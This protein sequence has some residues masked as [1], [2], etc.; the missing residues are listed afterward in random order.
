[1]T[2]YAEDFEDEDGY[3]DPVFVIEDSDLRA[4][5]DELRAQ[6]EAQ[7]AEREQVAAINREIESFRREHGLRLSPSEVQ[8]LGEMLD[9]GLDVESAY[10]ELQGRTSR[11]RLTPPWKNSSASR[12]AP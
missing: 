1:M 7:A 6:V 10:G 12:G 5:V 11:R 4:E 2:E 8:S 3:D 9:S